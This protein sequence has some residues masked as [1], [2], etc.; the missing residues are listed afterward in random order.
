M[1]VSL[2]YEFVFVLFLFCVLLLSDLLI[3]ATSFRCILS[4]H[5]SIISFCINKMVWVGFTMI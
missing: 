5:R 2:I 4:S 1:F 3:M